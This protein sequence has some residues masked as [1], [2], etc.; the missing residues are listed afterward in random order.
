M[1]SGYLGGEDH[2]LLTKEAVGSELFTKETKG[3]VML[4]LVWEAFQ[5]LAAIL[6]PWK[7]CGDHPVFKWNS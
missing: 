4:P 5:A 2:L 3:S 6:K 7:R 1:I